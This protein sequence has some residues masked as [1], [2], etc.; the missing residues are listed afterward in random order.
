MVLL[1]VYHRAIL[2]EQLCVYNMVI[3]KSNLNTERLKVWENYGEAAEPPERKRK[4]AT[5]AYS[6]YEEIIKDNIEYD[7]FVRYGQ[8]DKDRLDEIVSIILETVCS[9]RKA[10]R[11]AGLGERGL[12]N[13]QLFRGPAVVEGLGQ[14]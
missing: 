10:I 14:L 13:P 8:V 2:W 11:I 3:R 5:D 9:K 12:G 6:V 7:H 1:P 4:E